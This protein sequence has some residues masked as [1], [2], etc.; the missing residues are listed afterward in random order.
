MANAQSGHV[1][2]ALVGFSLHGTFPE[3]DISSS[4]IE[5]SHFA[6]ALESLAAA[7]SKLEADIHAINEETASDV[8]QWV[9]NAKS[10]EDDINRTR[11]WANEIVRRS[12]APDVSGKTIQEAEGKVHFLRQEAIYNDQLYSALTSIKH[13]SRLLDEV[14]LARDERRILQSLHL[15]EESWTALDSIPV[16]RSCRVMKLLDIRAFE[17]KSAVHDVFDRVWSS[18]VQVDS[19][20]GRVAVFTSRQD[21]QMN[22]TDAVIGLKAYKEVDKRM[23]VLWQGL[24]RILIHPRTSLE[25]IDVPAI[26]LENSTLTLAGRADKTVP[27]LFHD[28]E[29]VLEYLSERLPE[30]LVYSLSNIMMP[31]LIPHIITLWLEPAVPTSL[32][33]MDEFQKVIDATKSFH[34]RLETLNFS[35]FEELRE[36]VQNVPRV[37]LAKCRETALDSIRTKLSLGLGKPKEIERVETQI[38]SHEEGQRLIPNSVPPTNGDGWDAAWNDGDVATSED[39]RTQLNESD[40]GDG[41]ADAWGWGDDDGDDDKPNTKAPDTNAKSNDLAEEDDPT[42]AWGW[43]DDEDL[44]G[45]AEDATAANNEPEPTPATQELTLKETYNISS[46]PEPVIALI[47]AILEDGASLVGIDESPV[48]AAAAA[49]GLFSLPTLV[50][51]M[52]RA[53]SPHYYALGAGGNMFLYNDAT[54]LSE[55]LSKITSNWKARD[56]LV[57]RAKSMLRLDNDVKALQSFATRAYSSEMSTCRTILRDLLGGSQ[58]LLQQDGLDSS[59]LQSQ[60][61]NAINYVRTTA[62]S[63]SKILAKSAWSQAVGSLVDTIASKVV[64]D[65][66]D[67]AGIGQDDAYN[68]ANLIARITELDDLFLPPGADKSAIPSTSEYASSWLRLKYLSEVLQSNLQDVKFLWME[69]EL[70]LYFTVDEVVDLIGLS[71]VDNTRTREVYYHGMTDLRRTALRFA[72]TPSQPLMRGAVDENGNPK[73]PALLIGIKLDLE[74]EVHLTARLRGDIVIG[75]Y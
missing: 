9:A 33:D 64:T 44:T 26:R 69:S 31:D 55:Q 2:R 57:P 39:Q 41:G 53:V 29:I 71:F 37:W 43:G 62:A 60:V 51:A 1:G 14:E 8:S 61:D 3:E 27:S 67:L 4:H 34:T 32:K 72:R 11:N 75:L 42:A 40:D 13:V 6:P 46:M 15:L 20:T 16:S 70:S 59:D 38:V 5:V 21:E 30:E 58:S 66:M 23:A 73:N 63:W 35:G 19:S 18:L 7:K 25:G 54:Y 28:L 56:D 45:T 12:E 68:I 49:A 24:D 52:F 17:L 47:L 36:W 65:V 48:V 50:L 10:L 22:L 74:A